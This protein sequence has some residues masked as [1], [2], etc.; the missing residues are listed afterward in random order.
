MSVE[1]DRPLAEYC[2]SMGKMPMP[3]LMLN[4]ALTGRM[5]VLVRLR[6]YQIREVQV[7]L[8]HTFSGP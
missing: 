2:K 3:L 4:T 5:P 6:V 8:G 1:Y 7:L